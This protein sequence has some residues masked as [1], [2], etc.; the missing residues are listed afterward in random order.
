MSNGAPGGACG[1]ETCR[2]RS[3]GWGRIEYTVEPLFQTA[4]GRLSRNGGGSASWSRV[5]AKDVLLP[6]PTTRTALTCEIAILALVI[7][8]RTDQPD[9]SATSMAPS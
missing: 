9:T 1:C 4:A 6:C 8:L 2:D 5:R 3:C 7:T